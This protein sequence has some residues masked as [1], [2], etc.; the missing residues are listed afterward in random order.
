M[1]NYLFTPLETLHYG[2]MLFALLAQGVIKLN[3]VKELPFTADG[4]KQAQ[5]DLVD[6][7]TI[8]K[9]VIKVE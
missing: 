6:G 5:K 4:V 8:G 2:N 1:N 3:V 9:L 7:N